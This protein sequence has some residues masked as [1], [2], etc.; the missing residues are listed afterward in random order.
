MNGTDRHVQVGA[1]GM[2]QAVQVPEDDLAKGLN[3][4]LEGF[5]VVWHWCQRV[6][7]HWLGYRKWLRVVPVGMIGLQDNMY[8][9][10][11]VP[12]GI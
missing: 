11:A 7:N 8:N 3:F 4:D 5:R 2:L 10:M 9:Y 1:E 6:F 12:E